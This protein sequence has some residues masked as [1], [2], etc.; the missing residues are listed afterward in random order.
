M[1]CKGHS[2]LSIAKQCKALFVH[3]SGLNY[4][5]RGESEL[6]LKLMREMDE[7]YLHHPFKGARR[8]HIWLTKDKGYEVSKTVLSGFITRLLALGLSSRGNTPPA[9]VWSI[10]PIL[11]C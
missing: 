7:H 4:K 6:N 2:K 3:R 11:I 9:G 5:P 8:M 1:I 10:R